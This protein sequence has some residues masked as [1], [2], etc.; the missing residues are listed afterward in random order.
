MTEPVAAPVEEVV[1]PVVEA[2]VEVNPVE[3]QAREQGWVSKEEWVES[4]RDESEWRPAKE[5][6]E[7]GELYKSIHTTKRELKQ[8]QAALDA[9]AR[10]HKMVYEKAYNQA[11]QDLRTQKRMA[12][13]EGDLEQLE[14]VEEQIEKLREDHA[15]EKRQLEA[16]QNAQVGPP[17]E[18]QDFLNRNPWYLADKALKDEADA[19][20]F[21]YLNNGGDKTTLLPHVEKEMR[22]K[23]PEKFGV[24]R[25]APNAVAAVNRTGKKP[26]DS[27]ELSED[28]RRVMR[29]FVDNGV[30][31]EAE[32]VKE[33]KR[34]K[35]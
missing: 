10:H 16:Q 13:R 17:P 14:V 22:K 5:F 6:V 18:F 2:P 25:A 32:Y 34:L 21:I 19:I 3:E 7:R 4:G 8:T 31:T 12:I 20:G 35:Q 30:M 33:L 15:E 11:L 28:E 27:F 1:E 23:F 24:K 9:L 26:A 29:T